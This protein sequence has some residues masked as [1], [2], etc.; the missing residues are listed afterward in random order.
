MTFDEWKKSL[1]RQIPRIEKRMAENL[2]WVDGQKSNNKP[3]RQAE[4]RNENE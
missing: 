3:L 1:I 2:S 4:R